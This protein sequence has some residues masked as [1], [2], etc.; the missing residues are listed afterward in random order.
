MIACG[1]HDRPETKSDAEAPGAARK[2]GRPA[3]AIAMLENPCARLIDA[4]PVHPTVA[5]RKRKAGPLPIA[6]GNRNEE[7]YSGDRSGVLRRR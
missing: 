1:S 7:A 2:T 3:Q 4:S 5:G 6:L